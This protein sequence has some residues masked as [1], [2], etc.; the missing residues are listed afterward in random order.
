VSR[1]VGT[2]LFLSML[3]SVSPAPAFAQQDPNGPDPSKVK[4]RLG[5]VSLNPTISIANIGVDSNVFNEAIDPKHDFTATISPRTELYLRFLGTWFTGLVNEDLVWYQKYS[6][7][8]Q[9]NSTYG[10]AWKWPL[11]RLTIDTS[12]N[13]TSTRERSGYEIDSRAERAQNAF[14]AGASFRFLVNTGIEFTARRDTT[15]YDSA[16]QFDGV[17]LHDELNVIGTTMTVGLTQKLTPLTT[18]T[19]AVSRRQDR[20]PFNSLRDSNKTETRLSLAFDPQAL[21]K[22]NLSIGFTDFQPLSPTFPKYT[23]ATVA[24]TLSYTL[25]EV[26]KVTLAADR[27]VAN[28]YDITQPYFIQSGVALEIAQQI[29]GHFDVVGRGAFESLDYRDRVDVL[30]DFANR[31][32]HVFRYGAGLGYHQGKNLRIGFNFDQA[33]R[34]SVVGSR[35]FT[36]P[37]FGTSVTY[38]F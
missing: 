30:V 32:D 35:A 17:N 22:G 13:H 7:E 14:S 16:A 25:F 3:L 9:A 18:A 1:S 15:N 29:Y 33:R 38:D 28:S 21:L 20:F 37:T 31:T 10:L 12:A 6:T 36:R 5:P 27:Q 24:A 8:R 26:T 4:I 19:L 2:A 11:T 34:D 23:G